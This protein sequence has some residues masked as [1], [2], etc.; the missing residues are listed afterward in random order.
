MRTQA[1]PTMVTPFCR[2]GSVDY[3]AARAMVDWYFE[4]GCGGIFAACQSSEIF[5]LTRDERA[6]LTKT[7]VDRANE[8]AAAHPDRPRL[9]VVA[10]GH[11]SD[12][13]GDQVDELKAVADAGA[14]TVIL[15]S[16]RLDIENTGDEAWTRAAERIMNAL[17]SVPLGV[18]ECPHPYKRL[19]TEKMLSFCAASGRFYYMKDTCCDAAVMAERCKILAGTPMKL[20]NANAQTLLASMRSGGAG[21]CGVMCNFHPDLYVRLCDIWE[22]DPGTAD[23][24]QSF[25]GT[26]AFTESLAY[27]VTAKYHLKEIVGLP[28]ETIDAR[29]RPA[30]DLTDYHKS[31]V[32]QM[33]TLADAVR[34]WLAGREDAQ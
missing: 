3:G 29:T 13:F 17:P 21:Y 1:F 16:N 27:P 25:L 2:D 8:L 20:Y 9:T 12:A 5:F 32:R 18:Y 7:V 28:F 33:E 10:S 14:D 34:G 31:C 11:V 30:A 4:N 19:M 24:L 22:D 6:R 26:A 15:I 23:I